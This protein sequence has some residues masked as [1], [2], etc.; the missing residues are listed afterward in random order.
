M[1]HL[2][3]QALI[4]YYYLKYLAPLNGFDM[5]LG[6]GIFVLY[7]SATITVS[8]LSYIFIEK[9]F[10]NLKKYFEYYKKPNDNRNTLIN[11]IKTDLKEF[12]LLILASSTS[13]LL[14]AAIC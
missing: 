8:I 13:I 12:Y 2:I 1:W 5:T 3:I 9:P 14:G 10:L 4:N 7:C 11:E 6:V